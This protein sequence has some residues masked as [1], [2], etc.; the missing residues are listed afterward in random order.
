M[1]CAREGAPLLHPSS[2]F[3]LPKTLLN[4]SCGNGRH[5]ALFTLAS[6]CYGYIHRISPSK[7]VELPQKLNCLE[8]LAADVLLASAFIIAVLIAWP[9]SVRSFPGSEDPAT[10]NHSRHRQKGKQK[11]FISATEETRL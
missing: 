10:L 1:W 7:S 11:E 4:K 9:Y 3:H 2:I 5:H 8:Y 6:H